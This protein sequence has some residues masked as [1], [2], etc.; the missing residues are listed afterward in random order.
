MI[1]SKELCQFFSPSSSLLGNYCTNLASF[2]FTEFIL[3]FHLSVVNFLNLMDNVPPLLLAVS[4]P[5][6]FSSNCYS[7]SFHLSFLLGT[8]ADWHTGSFLGYFTSHMHL[9][10]LR[11]SSNLS[12]AVF[13]P[14]KPQFLYFS[15]PI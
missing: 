7:R 3:L 9:R 10:L 11:L 12:N 6:L 14:S 15:L 8:H 1:V 4:F 2:P 13:F 5:V